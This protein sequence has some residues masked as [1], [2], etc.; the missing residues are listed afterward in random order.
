MRS[1]IRYGVDVY[2]E[3]LSSLRRKHKLGVVANQCSLT[4]S[5][6]Y[7]HVALAKHADL[8]YIF[9]PQHGFF[10]TE[11]ANMIESGHTIDP[12]TGVP[13]VSLY[14]S[15]RKVNAKHLRSLDAL[16]VDLQDVG[17]R[18][19]TYLWT[20]YYC[21]EACE[22]LGKK[23]V[24]LDRPN[25][26][27][28]VTIEGDTL[29]PKFTSFVGLFPIPNR[30]GLTIG[31]FAM[32]LNKLKFKDVHLEVVRMRGWKRNSY[33]DSYEN[34]WIPAS[35]NIPT[36][37][38]A[39]VYSGMCLFEGTNLSEGRGTTRPFEILGAPFIDPNRLAQHLS[40]FH[41]E[42]ITFRPTFFKPTFDKF[43]GKRC[44]GVFLHVVDRKKFKPVRTAM[45]IISAV[46]ELYPK[47]FRWF[48]GPY[49]YER[50]TPAIDLLYGSDALRKAIDAGESLAPLF[51]ECEAEEKQF[52][53]RAK[54]W[55]LYT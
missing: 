37:H 55:W 31:E 21:M 8:K 17:S 11:Q 5:L 35:P 40:S 15:S 49:E 52:A 36:V 25:A 28:G 2:L 32:M 43:K 1:I 10:G 4:M 53:Q 19:Y 24:V 38:S 41:L 23:L 46:K 7:T 39:V 14:S 26:I 50:S 33:F 22:K 54:S 27:D 42:G 47:Q 45:T 13:I 18:Y 9:S 34:H 51:E 16:V 6:Q 48:L 3:R 29:H 20:L 44:G 30:Y 12:V